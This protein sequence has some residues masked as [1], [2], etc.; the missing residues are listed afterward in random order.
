MKR[1]TTLALTALLV[2]SAL[3]AQ[4]RPRH[5]FGVDAG[6]AIVKPEDGDA[7]FVLGTPVDVRVGFLSQ[8]EFTLEPRFT[9]NLAAGGGSTALDFSPT[10]NVL[11]QPGKRALVQRGMYVTGGLG[12]DIARATIEFEN[13]ITGRKET[14]SFSNVRPSLNIGVGTRRSITQGSFRPEAFLAYAFEDDDASSEL[15]VGVRLGL[16]FWR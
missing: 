2:P 16:S 11:Y 10:L 3:F 6:I 1:S 7:V 12:L 5:E 8:G 15:S 4:T 14:E 13:P 9:F